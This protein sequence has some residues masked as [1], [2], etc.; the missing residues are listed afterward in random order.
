MIATVT[1][2]R[3][4]V[5]F[6]IIDQRVLPSTE[7]QRRGKED[8][9]SHIETQDGTTLLIWLPAETYTRHILEAEVLRR[10]Q[11]NQEQREHHTEILQRTKLP[12]TQTPQQQQQAYAE[13]VQAPVAELQTS[14]GPPVW[15]WVII[16]LVMLVALAAIYEVARTLWKRLRR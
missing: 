11:A 16:I 10:T 9:M 3:G 15:V 4:Q 14:T 2:A 1:N 6:K 7:P 5:H 12:Q 13:I 8:V